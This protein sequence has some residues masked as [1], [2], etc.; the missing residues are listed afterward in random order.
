MIVHCS[1]YKNY[2]V[3]FTR[4]L[5]RFVMKLCA[6]LFDILAVFFWIAVT[7]AV[8]HACVSAKIHFYSG[9][10]CYFIK[11][12]YGSASAVGRLHCICVVTYDSYCFYF[13]LIDWK[14]I[15]FIFQKDNRFARCIQTY[16][17]VFFCIVCAL[18]AVFALN[19]EFLHKTQNSFYFCI[20]YAFT[21]TSFADCF[22]KR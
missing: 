3:T 22:Y 13:F 15:A 11:C 10:R 17:P 6:E 20:N 2:A 18:I 7:L 8:P 5:Y 14:N 1:A 21:Y 9:K 12:F 4:C 19:I 16:A